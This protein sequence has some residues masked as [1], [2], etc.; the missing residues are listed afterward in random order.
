[1]ILSFYNKVIF[2]I[3]ITYF[4]ILYITK[5]FLPSRF[6][7]CSRTKCFVLF[8]FE[9]KINVCVCL[10]YYDRYLKCSILF[11]ICDKYLFPFV[12]NCLLAKIGNVLSF[13][14]SFVPIIYVVLCRL[15][16]IIFNIALFVYP[17]RYKY[18]IK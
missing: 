16:I 1:L 4:V 13:V 12:C 11:Y 8:H 17:Y 6:L 14:L 15:E 2:F 9:N 18:L 5:S 3:S 7:Y 10:L